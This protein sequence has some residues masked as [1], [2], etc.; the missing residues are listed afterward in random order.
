MKTI[1]AALLAAAS[2]LPASADSVIRRRSESTGYRGMGAFESESL[3]KVSGVKAR[4][5]GTFKFTG[6]VLGRLSKKKGAVDIIRVDLDKHWTLDPKK[7]TYT[8]ASISQ[9]PAEQE[10]EEREERRRE[11]KA[12]KSKPTHRIKKASF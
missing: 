4:E 12:E 5:E 11:E 8:E 6:A 10:K 1:L 2:C 3:R 9:P 7:K